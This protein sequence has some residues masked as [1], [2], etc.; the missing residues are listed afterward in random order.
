M[1]YV[2][3]REQAKQGKIYNALASLLP[4]EVQVRAL[5]VD[6][7]VF[8]ERG[9]VFIERKT[10]MDLVMSWRNKRIFDQLDILSSTLERGENTK[11]L[12]LIEGSLHLPVKYGRWRRESVMGIMSALAIAWDKIRLVTVPSSQYTV[13]FL[14]SLNGYL[15]KT[16]KEPRPI[17]YKPRA[18]TREQQVLRVIEAFPSVG[19]SLSRKILDHFGS[20]YNFITRSEELDKIEGIGEKIKGEIEAVIYYEAEPPSDGDPPLMGGG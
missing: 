20:L 11:A 8:G 7:W 18:L 4:N 19:P 9:E 14:K 1:I 6:Y 2:D 15:G 3:T 5:P 10:S 17:D 16:E 12:L 13:L